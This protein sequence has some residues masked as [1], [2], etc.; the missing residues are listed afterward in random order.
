M[1][2]IITAASRT[3]PKLLACLLMIAAPVRLH[4]GAAQADAGTIK[5]A[6]WSVF[7]QSAPTPNRHPLLSIFPEPL[8]EG[9]TSITMDASSQFLRPDFEVSDG[10][11]TLVRFDGEDWGLTLDLA[12]PIGPLLLNLRLRGVWRTGGWADQAFASWHTI[13]G[14]PQGGRHEAPKFR[15]DYILSRDGRLVARLNSDRACFMDTDLAIL[16]PFG[17]QDTGGR[18]GVSLQAPTGSRNDFSGSGGWDELMGLALWKSLRDFRFHIQL[19]Y[20]F[21]GVGD[22]NPYDL[23]LDGRTQKRAWAGVTYQGRGGSFWSGL[24]LDITISYTES[25]YVTGMPRIDRPGWQQ[26]WTFTHSRLPKWRMGISE[27]AGTYTNP[28]LTV[29]L[30]YRF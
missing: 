18:A 15:L 10:G 16:Y 24:G 29:F 23:V 17:D 12:L 13:I 26:H 20:A 27:D 6:T 14:T 11:R 22:D 7:T 5:P 2:Q 28:D 19:E 21:L 8:P 9:K 1:R 4:P 30:Q 3:L 25:P